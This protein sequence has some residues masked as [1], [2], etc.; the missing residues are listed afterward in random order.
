MHSVS[1]RN[2]SIDFSSYEFSMNNEQW[3]SDMWRRLTCYKLTD[4]SEE[5]VALFFRV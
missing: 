4:V 3:S 1:M 2:Q 5:R